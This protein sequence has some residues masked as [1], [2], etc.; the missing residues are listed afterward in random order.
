LQALAATQERVEVALARLDNLRRQVAA[1]HPRAGSQQSQLDAYDELL[2]AQLERLRNPEP[3]GYRRPARLSEQ[4]AYL[5]YTIDQYD[6]APTRPQQMLAEMYSAETVQVESQLA[7]L[8]GERLA[9]LN[10]SLR[11]AGLPELHI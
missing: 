6:G 3:S 1:L 5:R 9:R 8:F 2:T 7:Q 11:A 10:T 4:L